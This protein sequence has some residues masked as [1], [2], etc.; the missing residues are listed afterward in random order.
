MTGEQEQEIGRCIF[1]EAQDAFFLIDPESLKIVD[2][3][4]AAQRLT[5]LRKKQLQSLTLGELI[6]STVDRQLTD[7]LKG[8]RSTR[9]FASNEGYFLRQA[10]G[11]RR[12][13]N[14]STSRIHLESGP[15]GLLVIRDVTRQKEAESA[16]RENQDR[17]RKLAEKVRLIPWEST[18]WPRQFSYVGPQAATILGYPLEAW[19][20]P[21]FWS[22]HL[23]PEDRAATEKRFTDCAREPREFD[24][25]YRMKSATGQEVWLHDLVHVVSDEKDTVRLHGF[26]LDVTERKNLEEDLRQSQKL[27]AIGRLASGVAHD[28]NNLLTVINGYSGYLLSKIKEK[29][30][31]RDS[32]EEIRKAAER[33]VALTSQLLA[34]GRRQKLQ[35]Q[36]LNVNQALANV[37]QMLR[38]VLG[39]NIELIVQM[40]PDIRAVQFDPRQLELVLLNLA[41][42][43][44]D[45][46]PQGGT[47]S[48][49]TQRCDR[50]AAG[51]PREL[52][53]GR[54]VQLNVTDTG[55]GMEESV[56]QRIFEPFF[57]TKTLGRGTGLGLAT[58]YGIVKQS[59][60]HI[61]VTS[62]TG[63]GTTFS[64]FLPETT[65]KIAPP[66]APRKPARDKMP[67]GTETILLVED[68]PELRGLASM[69]LRQSGY[70]VLEA[71]D[72]N[73]ALQL[74]EGKLGTVD[75]VLTDLVM[76][77]LG[78]VELAQELRQ[79]EPKLRVLYMSGYTDGCV[80]E[81]HNHDPRARLL[82]K[83]FMA[84]TL[85]QTV[86]EVLDA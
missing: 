65:A 66:P 1:R 16:L 2:V 5:G 34:F 84:D 15:L 7:L 73:S 53:P 31:Y 46:M 75:L 40:E 43:A 19:N 63:K 39:E 56:L 21:G 57:T 37:E 78:G 35:P 3:N 60:G 79:R 6:E 50:E 26:L 28:F 12:L 80:A 44:R 77:H 86:R 47:L 14:V 41:L 82:Q 9:Y 74:I 69:I 23:H 85:A 64:L 51:Q 42:N 8:C 62:A 38:R 30:A 59:G 58:V 76:P 32:V 25:E 20:A 27:E 45:A 55:C 13:I 68:E 72:G 29:T 18:A 49:I 71:A 48:M 83:P 17:F 4:P 54:Y 24:C 52:A 33:G 81:L 36:L 67:V 10:T 70:K 11:N 61:E 22:E